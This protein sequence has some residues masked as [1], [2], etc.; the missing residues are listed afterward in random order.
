MYNVQRK[1]YKAT[2]ERHFN[3]DSSGAQ[4]HFGKSEGA[5]LE[6]QEENQSPF[7]F[8]MVLFKPVWYRI[9]GVS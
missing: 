5:R 6:P 4:I 1:P 9:N 3:C 7:L 8:S 2:L